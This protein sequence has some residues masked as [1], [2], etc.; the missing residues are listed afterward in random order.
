MNSARVS[1]GPREPA[2][3]AGVQARRGRVSRRMTALGLAVIAFAVYNVNLRSVTSFD[4]YPARYLPISILI[5]RDLDLDEFP[6][7]QRYPGGREPGT[8]PYYLQHVRGHY[9]SSY[10]VGAAILAVPVYAIPTWIGLTAS[11]SDDAAQER[12]FLAATLLAKLA[13]SSAVAL[14]V[15]LVFLTASRRVGGRAAFVIALCYGFGTSSWSVSSQ[16]LWQSAMSQ[17]LLAL[18]IHLLARQERLQVELGCAGLALALATACRPPTVIFAGM[19][20]ML[21]W[22]HARNHFLK[23]AIGPVLIGLALMA[24]NLYYFGTLTGGYETSGAGSTNLFGMPS[25]WSLAGLLASPSRGLLVYSPFLGFAFAG[26]AVALMRPREP[27][28]VYTT[29]AVGAFLLF[30]S[31]FSIWHGAFSYSYRLLVDVLPGLFLLL[32]LVWDWI[33]ARRAARYAFALLALW[34]VGLQIIGAFFFP[35]GWESRPAPIR[36][37][38]SRLWDWSDPEFVRCLAAGPHEPEGL[39]AIRAR[40]RGIR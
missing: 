5:E 40:L 3:P 34:S 26:A 15:G 23:F 27:L 18:A 2:L 21:V 14:S 9:M 33:A 25:A 31:A 28:N 10:P 30:H 11:R 35:C 32:L 4:T 13:A 20:A 19:Y 37:A 7:I 12:T 6:S 39:R 1:A 8:V 36:S 16:G 17:P 29:A 24:Y 38:E 22:F